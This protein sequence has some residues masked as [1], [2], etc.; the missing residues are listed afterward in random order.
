MSFKPMG[1]RDD[2]TGGGDYVQRNYPEPKAGLRRA[3]VSLIV[4]LGVQ[5]R[6]PGDDGSEKTP[7]QHVAIFADLVNDTVDYG[8]EIGMAHYR[9]A[10]NGTFKGK[11]KGIG[12][13][14]TP[15]KDPVTKQ[16]IKGGKWMLHDNNMISKLAKAVGMPDVQEHMDISQLL[17]GQFMAQVE[18]RKTPSGKQDADGNEIVYTNVNFK[19]P[20]PVA[21]VIKEDAEGNEVEEVPVFAALKV[22]PK[23]ITF[24]NAKKE[25]V[26]LIRKNIRGIIKLA[27]NYAGSNMQKAIEAFEAED[28]GSTPAPA[29]DKVAPA[30]EAPAKPAP[31]AKPAL[32]PVED[33]DVPF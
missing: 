9:L 29:A 11:F 28:G 27:K 14:A 30:K 8:G 10:L 31:K 1:S 3:R 26:Q 21:A 33:D 19:Q 7:K 2:S 24:E 18:V 13:F 15:P 12:F 17:N 23:C 25:D 32:A 20:N 4:D 6:E 5:D 16:T 22:E